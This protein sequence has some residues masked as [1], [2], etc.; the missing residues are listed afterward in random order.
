VD[1]AEETKVQLEQRQREVRKQREAD[2]VEWQP[3]WFEEVQ[4][5]HSNATIWSFNQKYWDVREKRTFT[6]VVT[7]RLW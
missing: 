6:T 2:G 5:P 3:N 1:E 7:D 4:D